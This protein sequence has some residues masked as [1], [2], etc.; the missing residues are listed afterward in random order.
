MLKTAEEKVVAIIVAAGKGKRMGKDLSKQYILLEDK[1]IIAHTLEKF[2]RSKLVDKVI[3]VVGEDEI[4]FVKENIINKYL[5]KKVTNVIS[6]GRERQDSVYRGLLASGEDCGI[7]LVHDGVRPFIKEEIIEQSIEIAKRVGAVVVAVPVKDTIKRVNKN[8]Q[9]LETLKREELW[10]IQTP[11][12]FQYKLLKKAHESAKKLGNIVTDDGMMVELLGSHVEVLEGDYDNIKIT[13]PE[14][15]IM[16][17]MIL[18][19]EN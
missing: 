16:A 10:S 18:R 19:E 11:Q 1:P 14:D 6:G 8:M 13:T 12:T 7:V 5:F 2:E 3:L 15:L 9:V 17:Q 4:E